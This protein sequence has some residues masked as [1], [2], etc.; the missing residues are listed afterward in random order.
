MGP[1][2]LIPLLLVGQVHSRWDASLRTEVRARNGTVPPAT[3]GAPARP[4]RSADGDADVSPRLAGSIF[5]GRWN[6]GASYSPTFRSREPY[7]VNNRDGRPIVNHS[8]A[9]RVDL[10][11][12]KEASARAYL[13]QSV[14]YG[15]LD[16]AD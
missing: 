8:H 16:L 2:A 15:T 3:P 4:T 13:G 10:S 12:V 9:G 6:L 1:L 5:S 7:N 14:N 11:W